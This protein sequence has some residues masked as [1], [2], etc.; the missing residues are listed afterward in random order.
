MHP[1]LPALL[2][3][4]LPVAAQGLPDRF[5][6]NRGV[7][8]QSLNQGLGTP[9]RKATEALLLQDGVTVNPADYNAMHAMVGV[10]DLAAR[11]CVVEGA[12]ED[13]VEHLGKAARTA[14]T[15]DSTAEATFAKL[16][17]EHQAKLKTWRE[18]T[19]TQEQRLQTL[20]RQGTLTLEQ[21]RLQA[22]IQGFLDEH[23][24]A[25]AQ[26][27]TSLKEIDGLL[28]ALRREKEVHATALADWQAFLAKERSDIS[29][30]GT[31]TAY[32]AEK[33]EQVKVDDARPRPERLAYA[34]RLLRLDPSNP[35]CQR[36]VDALMGK[37]R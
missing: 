19:A 12:W 1:L 30:L 8:E 27:E 10:M 14:D 29:R 18:A 6:E 33:L 4:A 17:A 35:D 28:A 16:V 2:A 36:F 34:R 3:L 13:A 11:A 23:R 25:I 5:K 20:E 31:V 32:V 15:N 26:S 9:V 24:N 22:Q 7:W 37:G 21:K